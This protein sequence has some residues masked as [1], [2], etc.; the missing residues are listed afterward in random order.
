MNLKKLNS[1]AQGMYSLAC[2]F[3][4]KFSENL[5]IQLLKYIFFVGLVL[6]GHLNTGPTRFIILD[7]LTVIRLK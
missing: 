4:N 3:T 1:A 6:N 2:N 7:F 5:I